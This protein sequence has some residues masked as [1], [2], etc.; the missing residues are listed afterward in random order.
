MKIT[1]QPFFTRP[2]YK[3]YTHGASSLDTA[4]LLAVLLE[5]NKKS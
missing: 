4:E 3:L 2:G 5:K 1:D